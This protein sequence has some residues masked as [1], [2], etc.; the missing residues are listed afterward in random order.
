MNK[1][2]LTDMILNGEDSGIEFKR[3]DVANYRIAQELVALLNLD[4]GTLLLG[5][6]DDGSITGTPHGKTWKSGSWNFAGSRLI[7]R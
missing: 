2:E 4:G 3:D 7:R 6:D 1:A 5:V